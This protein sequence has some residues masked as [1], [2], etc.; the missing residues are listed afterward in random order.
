MSGESVENHAAPPETL[1]GGSR[2]IKISYIDI[3][4]DSP[5]YEEKSDKINGNK[6]SVDKPLKDGVDFD[7]LLPH[8]GNFGTYQRILFLLLA[9]YTLFYVFVY[10]TQIFI[11]LVPDDYW[12]NVPELL[13]LEA[14][15]RLRLAIPL[16]DGKM[17][18][19]TMYNVN[20]TEK[21]LNNITEANP[22]WPIQSCIFGYEFDH[23]EIPYTTIATELGWVCESDALPTIAQSVFFLGAITGG[24][25]F[26]WTA[27]RFGRVPALIGA[28]VV[29]GLAGIGT[30]F[31]HQFWSFTLCRY[32]A[33]FAFDNCYTL[34]YILALE[35]VGPKWRTFVANMGTAIFFG[36]GSLTMPWIAYGVSDWRILSIVLSAPL[37]LAI[38][39]PWIVPESAR[40]LLSQ[41]RIEKATK[42]I[43]KFERIN[44][45]RIDPEV[46]KSFIQT[47][48]RNIETQ[49]DR[50]YS[51]LDLFKTTKL[52][53]TTLLMIVIYMSVS[54]VYDGYIRSI[55]SIGLN[56]FIAFTLASA[57]EFP[58]S[59]ALTFVLDR[60]GRRWPL[61]GSMCLCAVCSIVLSFTVNGNVILA[62]SF[63]IIG[64]FLVNCSYNIGQQVAT[65]YLPTVVR[66]QGVAFVH[67]LGYVAN[68][69]SP[70]VIYLQVVHHSVPFWILVA[71]AI[72]GGTSIL[73]L[74]ETMDRALP[75]TLEDGEHFGDGF[76]FWDVPCKSKQR[77]TS[78]DEQ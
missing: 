62:M 12:C 42:I 2:E 43:H 17:S 5:L 22:L 51:L 14:S 11:T 71:V 13:H 65:E 56:L 72:I 47:C 61:F 70:F 74:P 78:K 60:W 6:D 54:L 39:T 25:I 32:F 44:K 3:P 53:K 20:Y 49:K 21:L 35:Y 10:F 29:G 77:N 26:G 9:P 7:D 58:A 50:N 24:I 40:W 41:N 73:F 64:R 52:R 66:A 55:T 27:D 36:L 69:I 76:K 37:V 48:Q 68:M 45:K 19:C 33:G 15:D 34:M 30:A 46:F 28:N 59:L 4:K 63:M 38:F 75:Q 1:E 23:S 16:N 18:Q 57:T 8:I 67:N 31:C